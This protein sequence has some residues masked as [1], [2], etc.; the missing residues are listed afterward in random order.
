MK[1]IAVIGASLAGLYAA[2]ALRSQG[3]DGR[4]TIV[5]DEHHRPYDRPPLSKNF[6][7]GAASPDQ[8]ALAD[9]E[10][11]AELDAEWL[12]GTRATGLDTGGRT[13][14]LDKRPAAGGRRRGRR[15]R[16]HTAPPAGPR[17]QRG[18]HAAHPGRRPGTARRS[19]PR[20]GPGRGDRRR[21][22]RGRSGLVLRH[23]GA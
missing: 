14:A 22:H 13:V 11:V 16:R 6:L 21:L 8:L 17:A 4:L 10:E 15:H 1:T 2:R 19:G 9:A 5:G 23:V 12:L 20:P 18:A 7:T 3:F